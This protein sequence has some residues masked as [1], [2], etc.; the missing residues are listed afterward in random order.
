MCTYACY[1]NMKERNV[2]M[3]SEN[4]TSESTKTLDSK[5]QNGQVFLKHKGFFLSV[6]DSAGENTAIS[7]DFLL[8]LFIPWC[9]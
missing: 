4:T 3:K 1:A 2:D 9:S 8:L 7:K 5:R 6:N